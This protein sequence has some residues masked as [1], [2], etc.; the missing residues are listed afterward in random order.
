MADAP[1]AR[2]QAARF[3]ILGLGRLRQ[4]ATFA[5]NYQDSVSDY[6]DNRSTST[7]HGFSEGYSLGFEYS[8]LHPRLLNGDADLSF[9]ADQELSNDSA[10]GSSR[11]GNNRI[12]YHIKGTVLDRKPNPLI[13]NLNSA[14]TTVRPPFSNT[15]TLDSRG[16]NFSWGLRNDILPVLLLVNSTST[17]TSGLAADRKNES[18]TVQISAEHRPAGVSDTKLT[19]TSGAHRQ[20]LLDSGAIDDSK[21]ARLEFANTL[22]W[23]DERSLRRRLDTRYMY[24]DKSGSNPTQLRNFSSNLGWEVGKAL[25]AT[26]SVNMN[27]T[28]DMNG[29][30]DMKTMNVTL[31]HQYLRALQ[32]H[33]GGGVSRGSYNDGSDDAFGWNGGVLYTK[34]LPGE[35]GISLK[36]DYAQLVQNRDRSLVFLNGFTSIEVAAPFPLDVDLMQENVDPASLRIFLDEG[37]TLPFTGFSILFSGTFTRL[38]INTDPGTPRLYLSYAY[39]QSPQVKFETVSQSVGSQLS[40]NNGRHTATFT[41]S[42]TDRSILDG[43]DPSLVLEDTSTVRAKVQSSLTPHQ[44]SLEYMRQKGA[45]QDLQSLE[46]IWTHLLPGRGASLRTE[47]RD[48]YCWFASS[49][50]RGGADWDNTILLTTTY[51]R[52]LPGNFKGSLTLGYYNLANSDSINHRISSNLSVDGS[53]GRTVVSLE[54]GYGLGFASS[55]YSSNQSLTLNVR[56]MF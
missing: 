36:Y 30:S 20:T 2:A 38:R 11:S 26:A 25:E 14:L 8:I 21:E 27:R 29:A 47:A 24:F 4:S 39:R 35:S 48:R 49:G 19:L 15:Y 50:D 43:G 3:S 16:E 10:Q 52:S 42:W 51:S 18:R 53:Y 56:R 5:Y 23:N 28:D 41:Y 12:S 1:Q 31:N 32:T 33:L 13:F 45:F 44:L 17:T 22:T 9:V 7:Q 46:A 37:R 34:E 55:G 54:G 40:M 6:S